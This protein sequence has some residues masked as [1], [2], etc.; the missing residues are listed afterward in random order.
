MA[1]PVAALDS[2]LMIVA[3]AVA[4]CGTSGERL[5]GSID[6][7]RGVFERGV[8]LPI[9]LPACSV[10]HNAPSGPTTASPGML[11]TVGIANSVIVPP[12][13]RPRMSPA[14]SVNQRLPS[15]P[16]TRLW[17]WLLNVGVRISWRTRPLVLICAILLA[18]R[19]VNQIV[20]S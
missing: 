13:S 5:L 1:H 2:E 6:A 20:P 11:P 9:L 19:S 7:R 17:G 10:N 8:N 16:M 18:A 14:C 12:A 4:A 15:G 3:K